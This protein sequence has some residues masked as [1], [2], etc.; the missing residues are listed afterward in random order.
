MHYIGIDYGTKRWGLS[1]AHV[2]VGIA[3]PLPPA[4]Q[5]TVQER[6][7]HLEGAIKKLSAVKACIIGY[8]RHLNGALGTLAPDVERFAAELTRRFGVAVY[9]SDE[10]LTSYVASQYLSQQ[11]TRRQRRM[12]DAAHAVRQ[13]QKQRRSGQTDSLSATLLLQD[14]LD[15]HTNRPWDS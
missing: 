6:W 15:A 7:Q 3:S 13:Q 11:K 2:D 8:P 10:T 1:S 5:R 9:F 4:C 14:Y 12:P